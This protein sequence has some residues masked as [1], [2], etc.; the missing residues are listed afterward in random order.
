[1][2]DFVF[3]SN[4]VPDTPDKHNLSR[5]KPKE[6][7]LSTFQNLLCALLLS[8]LVLSYHIFTQSPLQL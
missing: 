8:A 4:L 6:V 7:C 1:M 2:L 3:L 5:V